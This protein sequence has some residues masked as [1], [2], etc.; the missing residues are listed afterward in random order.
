TGSWKHM[1]S[2]VPTSCPMRLFAVSSAI[3]E[4]EYA[5]PFCSYACAVRS[6]L[7][8]PSS[9]RQ[10]DQLRNRISSG[11]Y[12]GVL[13]KCDS[14][15]FRRIQCQPQDKEAFFAGPLIRRV[16]ANAGKHC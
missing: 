7:D 8:R 1:A 14:Q 6:L 13:L 15:L 12:D 4:S 16:Y 11:P 5:A 2:S 3:P 9:V 10:H